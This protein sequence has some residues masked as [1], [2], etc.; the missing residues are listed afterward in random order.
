MG[1]RLGS[2]VVLVALGVIVA[3][4]AL[5]VSRFSG[6]SDGDLT[7]LVVSLVDDQ[8]VLL[9]EPLEVEVRARSGAPISIVSLLVEGI[10]VNQATPVYD[11]EQGRYTAVLFWKPEALGFAHLRI[12]VTDIDGTQ[13]E[14]AVRV[15]VTDDTARVAQAQE[16]SQGAGQ[17]AAGTSTSTSASGDGATVTSG[18]Q[19]GAASSGASATTQQAPPAGGAA[20][21]LSP[22]DGTE[23]EL[24][25]GQAF[26]VEIETSGTGPLSSVLFYVTPVLADGS[27]GR[28]Q[29]AHSATPDVSATGIYREV[30][31]GVEAWFF[32][33]RSY[34]L[35]LV[36]LT[37]DQRRLEDLVR[38]TV[39]GVAP[40]DDD[41]LRE[42]EESD[43][44][45]ADDESAAS[46]SADLAILTARQDED[47]LSVTVINTGRSVAE[48]VEVDISLI[49]SRDASLLALSAALLT[50]EPDQRA[51][52]PLEVV[53]DEPT[54]ALIVL[55]SDVDEDSTNNTF[56]IV[57]SPTAA[58]EEQEE[59]PAEEE[60][61]EEAAE[62][63]EEAEEAE[64]E[65]LPD[66]AFLEARFTDD[67]F[68]LLTVVNAGEGAA[69]DF[70]INVVGAD[71]VVLET[72]ERGASAAP[73]ASR[74]SEILAGSV[75]H[76]GTVVILLDP[77][78]TTAESN[79]TN[80]LIRV[81]VGP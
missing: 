47:G 67:G 34:D 20:R 11:N 29:L 3:V 1:S 7:T 63:A 76:S 39:R 17:A 61:A 65:E 18:A 80:N 66:L 5:L 36:A 51:N 46:E 10:I 56:E 35:Q 4:A 41:E 60:E 79:E 59:A 8:P 75:A 38:I 2:L 55:E 71:G 48:R 37:V 15:D 25:S 78:D 77:N 12:V 58:S 52:I 53:V 24:G 9:G 69:G 45:Q 42:D 32:E 16:A 21:I 70:V 13:T 31:R 81:E 64:R 33:A 43:E 26:D 23:Y 54:E 73:L 14:I 72:I 49:R 40:A 62:E 6:G 28:S 30:V 22:A 50:L 44:M 74:D 19:E 68:A 57:L 27:F